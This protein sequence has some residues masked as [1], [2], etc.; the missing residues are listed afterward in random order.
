MKDLIDDVLRATSQPEAWQIFKE[1]LEGERRQMVTV[2][3]GED[4]TEE[5]KASRKLRG[6]RFLDH[7]QVDLGRRHIG[8]VLTWEVPKAASDYE[9]DRAADRGCSPTG[10][11]DPNLPEYGLGLAADWSGAGGKVRGM[12]GRA[13]ST[14]TW[15]CWVPE[16]EEAVQTART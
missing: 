11:S 4:Q 6:R 3:S 5:I 9:R 13:G 14:W 16:V 7:P 12:A 10:K 2:A 15:T 1:I 8:P